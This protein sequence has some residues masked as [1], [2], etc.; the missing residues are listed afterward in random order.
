MKMSYQ[1]K[2]L[3]SLLDMKIENI[4]SKYLNEYKWYNKIPLTLHLRSLADFTCM[5]RFQQHS[6]I[7]CTSMA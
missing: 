6:I 2:E 3:D 1:R 4:P 5:M 7:Y